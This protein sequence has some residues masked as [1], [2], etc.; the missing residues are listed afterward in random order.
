MATEHGNSVSWE[1]VVWDDD[2]YWDIKTDWELESRGTWKELYWWLVDI[3]CWIGW[4]DWTAG[5]DDE[6]NWWA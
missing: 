3:D 4:F 5:T 1:L 6:T 2:G